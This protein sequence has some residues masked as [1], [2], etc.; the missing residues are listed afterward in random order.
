MKRVL[1]TSTNRTGETGYFSR[2]CQ[3]PARH[4]NPCCSNRGRVLRLAAGH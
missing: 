2:L 3:T 4:R 1:I